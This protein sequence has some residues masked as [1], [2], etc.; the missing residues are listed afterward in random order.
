MTRCQSIQQV[1]GTSNNAE[2]SKVM[3]PDSST[4]Y[5]I[6]WKGHTYIYDRNRYPNMTEIYL[7]P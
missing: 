1:E 5:V 4:V 6:S 2:I 7:N 3:M